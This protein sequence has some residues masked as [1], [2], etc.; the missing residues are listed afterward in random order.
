MHLWPLF[1]ISGNGWHPGWLPQTGCHKL[2]AW[3]WWHVEF[4]ITFKSPIN[5]HPPKK[6]WEGN[7]FSHVCLFIWPLPIM[8]WTSMYTLL[9]SSAPTRHQTWDPGHNPTLLVASCGLTGDLF[10]LNPPLVLT[11]SG[12]HWNTYG[13]QAG[14]MLPTGMLS[15]YHY[16]SPALLLY[17]EVQRIKVTIFTISSQCL[18][19][20]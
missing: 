20:L 11:S 14:N 5:Y 9:P 13:W 18:S 12:G 8:Y 3:S 7:V 17:W 4:D 1:V 19:H 10:K 6:L 16:I 2:A 15:C